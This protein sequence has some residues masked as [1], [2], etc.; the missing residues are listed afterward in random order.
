ML[1]EAVLNQPLTV[2]TPQFAPPSNTPN[3]VFMY[4]PVEVQRFTLTQI[5]NEPFNQQVIHELGMTEQYYFSYFNAPR[6]IHSTY[7]RS[8]V[9]EMTE[10]QFQLLRGVAKFPD[11]IRDLHHMQ[12]ILIMFLHH[13]PQFQSVSYLHI[14]FLFAHEAFQKKQLVEI[15]EIPFQK[16][17][18]EPISFPFNFM[19]P[20]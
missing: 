8:V 9:Y 20:T 7:S 17:R 18:N 16:A 5:A 2:P 19:N 3:Q 10:Y 11:R 12:K 13:N 14:W 4:N 15:P 6:T 1:T